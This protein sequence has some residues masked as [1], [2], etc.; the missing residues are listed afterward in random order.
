MHH[1]SYEII[2]LHESSS[3]VIKTIPVYVIVLI[4]KSHL[5]NITV[6]ITKNYKSTKNF[7]TN[8]YRLKRNS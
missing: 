2:S 1:Y 7:D 6:Q 3:V 5:I 4:N 8:D